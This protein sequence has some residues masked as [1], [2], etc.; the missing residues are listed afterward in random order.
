MANSKNW[1][2]FDVS[3]KNGVRGVPKSASVLYGWGRGEGTVV[4]EGC[5]ALGEED[6]LEDEIARL[7][8]HHQLAIAQEFT[9]NGFHIITPK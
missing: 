4:T 2:G 6:L 5:F 3:S 9:Q 8:G 1:T 7:H